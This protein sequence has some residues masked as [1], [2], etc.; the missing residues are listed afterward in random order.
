[1]QT[2]LQL[3]NALMIIVYVNLKQSLFMY[4]MEKAGA[5]NVAKENYPNFTNYPEKNMKNDY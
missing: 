1:M 3:L 5:L 2:F 4:Y